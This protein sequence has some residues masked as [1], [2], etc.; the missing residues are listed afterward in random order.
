LTNPAVVRQGDSVFRF[1]WYQFWKFVHLGGVAAFLL[2]HGI[3]VGVAFKLRGEREPGRIDALLQLSSSS[4]GFLHPALGILVLGGIVGGF[5]GNWWSMGWIWASIGILIAV[6]VLMFVVGTR[7]YQRV[8]EIV[9]AMS[10]GSE[11]VSPDQLQ[12][13][14]R[15]PRAL[16]NAG[17]GF[18]GILS[19]L[20][21]MI[22][23]PF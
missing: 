7:Y 17:I 16:W 20:Y 3:S 1:T 22:F 10:A 14:L 5:L 23:K 13:V 21:L 12:Q 9:G 19:I 11:A 15:A 8:R 6:Y 2:A 18:V 4:I